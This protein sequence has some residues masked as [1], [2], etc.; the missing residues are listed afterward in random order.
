MAKKK[1]KR[2][3]SRG[4]VNDIILKT[5][6]NGD[7]YGYEIIKEVEMFSDGKVKL[8]QPSLYSSLSRFEEKGF[9]NS[10]WGDSDI[11]GRRHYYHLTEKGQTY[12]NEKNANRFGSSKDNHQ[13]NSDEKDEFDEEDIIDETTIDDSSF[14][15]TN[16][17]EIEEN[18]INNENNTLFDNE[19]NSTPNDVVESN[20]NE[21]T[22]Q[23]DTTEFIEEIDDVPAFLNFDSKDDEKEI[24]PDHNFKIETPIEK[25]IEKE[26]TY[27]KPSDDTYHSPIIS[28]IKEDNYR[29]FSNNPTIIENKESININAPTPKPAYDE[30]YKQILEIAKGA[31]QNNHNYSNFKYGKLY[32]K[33]PKKTKIVILDKDGIY[34]LRD[35]DYK[36]TTTSKTKII[37]NVGKRIEPKNDGYINYSLQK[38]SL[39][40]ESTTSHKELTEEERKIRNEN[41][42]AKFNLLTKSKMKPVVEKKIVE[43]KP[44]PEIDYRK[45]LDIFINNDDTD[46]E[47]KEPIQNNIYNYVDEE[48]T[49]PNDNFFENK[50]EGED[51]EDEEDEYINFDPVEF[52][53]KADDK[54]YIEEISN[55]NSNKE[56][57]KISR[58]ENKSNAILSDKTY[59]LINK[60]KCL[61]G[62]IMLLIMVAEV[63]ISLVLFK[64]SDVIFDSDKTLL[65]IAYALSVVIPLM[66]IVPVFINPNEHKINNFKLK[67][68]EIFGFLTFLVSII[69]VYCVN[70]LL[71]FEL[72][73]FK[74]FAVKLILPVVLIFNLVILPPIY[75]AIINNKRYYD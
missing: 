38:T 44:K 2:I 50:N 68:S 54:K 12:F 3:A 18:F 66:F 17:E 45:K 75:S 29:N 39:K 19:D 30:E 43:E 61:F 51:I 26:S 58:Y 20:D 8:K 53:A 13:I 15:D 6:V 16:D 34:K 28:N 1:R 4:S 14:D 52:E 65:I 72:T 74:Y 60:V 21:Q 67:Y 35:A 71:G 48:D 31:K 63:S 27:Q 24:I 40:T 69:L 64:K 9:V 41:F 36:P 37:D 5:L 11:G 47:D 23:E 70:A 55:F 56:E 32:L 33:T 25:K 46:E 22:S 59:V 10:Y 42:L 7:K 62:I 73:N 57:I 49:S